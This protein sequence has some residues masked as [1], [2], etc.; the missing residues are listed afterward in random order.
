MNYAT[1]KKERD[2]SKMSVNSAIR[3]ESSYRPKSKQMHSTDLRIF[4]LITIAF[5]SFMLLMPIMI[6]LGPSSTDLSLYDSDGFLPAQSLYH[7]TL[8]GSS[9]IPIAVGTVQSH[10]GFAYVID[11][12]DKLYF[13][14]IANDFSLDISIP[15]GNTWSGSGII[16]CDVDNDGDSEFM[17]RNYVNPQYYIL[18][19][20]LDDGVVSKY[21]VP[22]YASVVGF[23]NFSGDEYPDAV[24]K[25]TNNNDNFLTFD[26]HN[27]AT[28]GS[29]LLDYSYGLAI[30]KF[31]SLTEDSI[32]LA[33]TAG[34]SGQRNLTLVAAD[35]SQLQSILLSYSIQD[36]VTF[37]WGSGLDEIATIESN[38]DI[39]VY[40]GPTLGVS[41]TQNVDLLYSSYRSI[42]TGDF[43][44]DTQEDLVIV[45]RDQ[46][47]AYFRNG[48]MGFPIREVSGIYIPGDKKQDVG[49]MDADGLD[50]LAIGTTDGGL[51]IVRGNDGNLA[52]TEYLIDVRNVANSYQ[53]DTIDTNG[54]SRVDVIC[55]V[56]G[57]V[58]LLLSDSTPPDLAQLP[59]EPSHPTILDDYVTIQ[60]QVN[61][62][63]DI[64]HAD[65][66]MRVGGAG[67]WIQPQDEMYSSHSEGLYY[68]FIGNL[69]TGLYEY[70]F[71]FQD[72]YLNTIN[73]G[74]T[75]HPLSFNV[76]GNFVWQVD[77]SDTDYV[78]Y[79]AHQSDIGNLSDGQ[80]V[81]YTIERERSVEDLTLTQYSSSGAVL[82]NV[83]IVNGGTRWEYFEVY[84]AMLDGDNVAD[85]IVLDYY[86]KSGS[87]L[88]YHAYHGSTLSLINE[89]ISPYPYKSFNYL[90]VI[91]DD[92]D[93]N[94]ELLLV[95]DTSPYSIIKMDSDTSWSQVPIAG[96]V[97]IRGF[98]VIN[99]ASTG[100]GYIA[101]LRSSSAIDLHNAD[102][103]SFIRSLD[104]DLSAY[105][106][107][108]TPGIWSRYN[109]LT[110]EEEFV[111]A[112]NYWN[113]SDPTGR[114]LVFDQTTTNM[115]DTQYYA[116]PHEDITYIFPHDAMGSETDEL[117]VLLSSG[118]LQL[119]S[120]ETSLTTH[121]SIQVTGATPLSAVVTD[122]DG[123][124]N[125]EFLLFTDQDE[126][127]TS[128]SLHGVVE[129]TVKVGEVRNPLVIGNIDVVP[130]AEI[131]AY[132]FA[133]INSMILGAVRNLDSS[134][135][136]DVSLSYSS[137]DLVQG[138]SFSVNV[139]VLDIHGD[140]VDDA[141][142]YM[143]AHYMTPEGAGDN[144]FGFYYWAAEGKYSALTDVTW[145]IGTINLT[146]TVDNGFYHLFHHSYEN[147]LVVRSN[148]HVDL[149]VPD[150]VQQ[151]VNTSFRAIIFDNLGGVVDDATVT[152]SIDSV[153]LGTI[154]SGQAHILE[155][156]EVQLEAGNHIA[157]GRANHAYALAEGVR[158][159]VF[160]VQV[161]T[162][163]L[164]I[165]TDFPAIVQQDSVVGAW[166]N[167][168]DAYGHV[169]AGADV[170]LRSG[171]Q[172]YGMIESPTSPG[173]YRFLH[174]IS[175]GIGNQTFELSVN[176]P[177]VIG[178]PA[179]EISFDVYG[180]LQPNVFY[181]TRVEGGS[182]FTINI[183]VKDKYGPVFIGT[184][185]TIDINGTLYT[186]IDTTGDP[187]YALTVQ[188]DFLMGENNFTIYVNATF[189]NPW[190][191]TFK[192]RAYSDAAAS[193]SITSSEGW[194]ILQGERTRLE[195][196]LEDWIGR[197]VSG[198]TVQFFVKALSYNLM[199]IGQGVYAVN[200][201]TTG[202]APGEY[203]Y[204]VSVSHEDIK[205]G[206]AI[207][208]NITI[209]GVLEFFV[210]FNPEQ[211]S[212]GESL[213]IGI[214]I[215]D[216]YG[217]PVPGLDV[218]VTTMGMPTMIAEE[219][220][221]MG[222]YILF[223]EHLPI[224]EGY[225]TKNIS[226]E[227][228]GQFVQ[229]KE[230]A[231]SFYLSVAEPEIGVMDTPTIFTFTGI[232][233]IV[234]L[235]GM[236][237]YFR[238]A[239]TLRRTYSSKEEL[240]RAVKRMDRLYILIILASIAGFIVST[241]LYAVGDYG[242]A[243]ILTVALLG[244]SVLLYGL[245][246]YRDAVSAVMVTGALSKKRMIAGLGHL[247]FVPVVIVMILTY[248]TEIDW[249]KAYMIDQAFTIGEISIPT[250][251]TTIF[252]AYL[253][254]I[255][256]VVVNLYREVSK[257]LKRIEKMKDAD[258][259]TSII[260]DERD[261]LVSRF[262]SS[263]RIKFLMF[264]V[265]VG[266]AAVTTMDFLQSY[267]L[268]VIVLMPIAFLVVIPF[269][270]SK[271]VQVI[272]RASNPT[273]KAESEPFVKESIDS[274]PESPTEDV[275]SLD[276][277]KDDSEE[278]TKTSSD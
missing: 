65:I 199:E 275:E 55:R 175:L 73:M 215:V 267:E 94:Q 75:T 227:V 131:A 176:K 185:V 252:T 159:K 17:I 101:I 151:G 56:L 188:A 224:T 109:A 114:I 92:G 31:A 10:Q 46:E 6:N 179:T 34:T 59:M 138:E 157:V 122:F 154:V 62:T 3:K 207:S 218:F 182:W 49:P 36:M 53:I 45:S 250:I 66:F 76:M 95:S 237:I 110:G 129:W 261:T 187:D 5:I 43:N 195:L 113:G 37:Q 81:I 259:P 202:W 147:A 86:Y 136:L 35:G 79:R 266:A 74:N 242:G 33:N 251:M 108:D 178:P 254:S 198:A 174:T 212:Q 89:G 164:V 180:N 156:P 44:L 225:G 132:P 244:A 169:I 69:V 232:S 105:S 192:I 274:I 149:Q 118:E 213:L 64:E 27:N 171:P 240:K 141:S 210:D 48:N 203:G 209:L 234:S 231:T 273:I 241:Q 85:I 229:S 1:I 173:S 58:Y 186:Q 158:G 63:S 162:E 268:G 106:D 93:G 20:D 28:I 221:Q 52:Y 194:T 103:L 265:V 255:L 193:A 60:I 165:S 8:P 21:P 236:F 50:D 276:E 68:A 145:P 9:S 143:T 248:G 78:T 125:E 70:Y 96:S 272:D 150:I 211:P 222:L 97:G 19:V 142:I 57:D 15:A 87:F 191:G 140:I 153:V 107:Q 116:I 4:R 206:N 152:I 54:D 189:A 257:G 262:S 258:T 137:T 23:G 51:G 260:Q 144:T 263:I 135:L 208:G 177:D 41:Y 38:G 18:V 184:S 104:V 83:T 249:F 277:S 80:T 115:N 181:E 134:Y 22:F 200:M 219:S 148:L 72:T 14:D 67:P 98:S 124:T 278:D 201:S 71:E 12:E 99:D 117:M 130:G 24:I 243:L 216:A 163:N 29:F 168:S 226:I 172:V 11:D 223:I 247:F 256:V 197:P 166:F 269:I 246:L 123:D 239:P 214:T 233:F 183:F 100:D 245:W 112:I 146:I 127:L 42:Q 230:M 133:S 128:V 82:D 16:A 161:L 91:D 61:E 119:V 170:T 39:V 139:T 196:T 77:K 271:I 121:W 88:G 13:V 264:L 26:L 220:D 160:T 2:A 126:L 32:A 155:I 235:L 102:D 120:A 217:N 253:S 30:G 84:T 238:L 190:S 205:S 111:A 228:E 90:G 204:S 40:S 270:S 25:N 7:Y 47:T 167:I